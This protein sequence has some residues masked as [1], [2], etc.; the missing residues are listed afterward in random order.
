MVEGGRFQMRRRG[1][2][3]NALN[4]VERRLVNS[5]ALVGWGIRSKLP[6]NARRVDACRSR[7]LAAIK[8]QKKHDLI[9]S[10]IQQQAMLNLA[11][12]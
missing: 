5:P 9:S 8:V 1:I 2:P 12:L 4:Q 6:D 3:V 10:L 7:G 11:G